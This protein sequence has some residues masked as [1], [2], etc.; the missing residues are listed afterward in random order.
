[1]KGDKESFVFQL[2]EILN[3]ISF[4]CQ[5]QVISFFVVYSSVKNVLST[6]S[7]QSWMKKY[8]FSY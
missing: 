6:E 3:G 1:M 8:V 2:S 5:T 4:K 7:S